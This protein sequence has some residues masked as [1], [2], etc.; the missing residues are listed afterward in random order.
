MNRK[1][2]SD[3]LSDGSTDDAQRPSPSVHVGFRAAR[4][5]LVR[6]GFSAAY[7]H[8]S[9]ACVWRHVRYGYSLRWHMP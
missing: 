8:S 7:S 5:R 1:V 2:P 3:G 9:I 4:D 6:M